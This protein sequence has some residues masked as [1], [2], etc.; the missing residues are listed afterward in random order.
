MGKSYDPQMH[1]AEHIMNQTMVRLLGCGRS[2]SSHLNAGKSKCDY[3][4]TRDLS[5]AEAAELER[6]VNEQISR[7]QPVFEEFVDWDTAAKLVNV[8]HLPASADRSQKLRLVRVGDYDVCA[9]IGEHVSNT[10]EIGTFTLVSHSFTPGETAEEGVL[11]L[12]F[13]VG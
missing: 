8:T 1:S 12:R 13:K 3:H 11:R 6:R 10:A 4:F 5:D 2:F 9:C 7:H